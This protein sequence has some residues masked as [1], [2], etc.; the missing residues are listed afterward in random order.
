M[1]DQL[2]E[3]TRLLLRMRD[4][5][6]SLYASNEYSQTLGKIQ[7]QK[8]IY[9]TDAVSILFAVLPSKR[10]FER[11][12]RGPYDRTV[13][14]AVDSLAFRG[15]VSAVNE[16]IWPI[17]RVRYSLTDAGKSW[18]KVYLEKVPDSP[19]WT[20]TKEV[21]VRVNAIG[22]RRLRELVYAE[23]TFACG[24]EDGD[25]GQPVS[26]GELNDT[27]SARLLTII[28]RLIKIRSDDAMPD[29]QLIL[30]VFFRYLDVYSKTERLTRN[31]SDGE[32]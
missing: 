24:R 25:F 5:G 22:W 18:I 10:T 17:P 23:P 26:P 19:R 11:Y 28:S 8:F 20:A 3:S 15:F 12:K 7:M 29:P 30:D 16:Q 27:S 32:D 31:S 1:K 21:A 4:V 9:L 13:Q 14:N 2:T 6:L